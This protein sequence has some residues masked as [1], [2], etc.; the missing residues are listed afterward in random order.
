M[1]KKNIIITAIVALVIS[2]VVGASMSSTDQ[3]N[4]GSVRQTSD[5]F[6]N[7]VGYSGGVRNTVGGVIGN[8]QNQASWKNNTGKDAYVV[9]FLKPVATTTGVTNSPMASSTMQITAGT[10]SAATIDNYTA[11]N[12]LTTGAAIQWLVATS[13]VSKTLNASSTATFAPSNRA[14]RQVVRVANGEYLNIAILAQASVDTDQIGTPSATCGDLN[15]E[16]AT[17]TN[18]GFNLRWML[19]YTTAPNN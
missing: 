11:P 6:V 5:T 19:E 14:P 9:V 8:G 2:L 10:S 3:S 18:R 12:S 17:S 4:L 15:C 16:T 1:D 7:G 13:S